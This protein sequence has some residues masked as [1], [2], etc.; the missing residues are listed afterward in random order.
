[1]LQGSRSHE[2]SGSVVT[3]AA[4]SVTK[5]MRRGRSL[6]QKGKRKCLTYHNQAGNESVKVPLATENHR[7]DG[8]EP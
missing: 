7:L 5:W 1:V 2:L 8:A 4:S 3:C 6:R